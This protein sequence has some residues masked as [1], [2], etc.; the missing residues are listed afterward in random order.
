MRSGKINLELSDGTFEFNFRN[1]GKAVGNKNELKLYKNSYYRNGIKLVPW[2][3]TKYGIIKVSDNEYKVVNS[4]GRII[5]ARKKVI[6]DDYDNFIIILNNKLAGYVKQTNRKVQFKWRTINGITG[7]YYYDMDLE[8]KK[9]TNLCIEAGTT[10]PTN[11][12]LKDI[13]DDLKV[14]FK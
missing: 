11:A 10:E 13:P 4:N 14:N 2:E 6:I 5:N 9:I 12:M 3:D 8:K 7:Y 1:S